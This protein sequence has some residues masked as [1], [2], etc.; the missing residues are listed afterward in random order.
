MAVDN[1]KAVSMPKENIDRAIKRGTGEGGDASRIEEVVYEAYGPNGVAMLIECLTDN[2]NR[3]IAEIKS[4]MNKAGGSIAGAGSVAY[5]FNK[6]GEITIDGQKNSLKG[7][8][9]ELAIIES[10]A[11]DFDS[12]DGFYVVRTGFS[13][14]HAVKKALEDAGVVTDSAEVVQVATTP[15]ELPEDKAESVNSMIERL[16]ELDDVTSVYTN[17][18]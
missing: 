7:E 14:L 6:V 15:V 4:I 16:E 8:D 1:A 10:G 17:L 12:E 2:R 5:Q 11:E 13:N 3:T 9:L 18:A